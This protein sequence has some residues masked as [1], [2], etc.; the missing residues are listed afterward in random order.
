MSDFYKR[1]VKKVTIPQT[2]GERL[3]KACGAGSYREVH[4]F[5]KKKGIESDYD[6]IRK[7][8]LGQREPD[9][10][11]LVKL[12]RATGA[13][14]DWLLTGEGDSGVLEIPLSPVTGV[15][16]L[17]AQNVKFWSLFEL[18]ELQA[19]RDLAQVQRIPVEEF[20]YDLV[21]QALKF[22][23][24]I[25]Y[26]ADVNI[27]DLS[28][29][30]RS[31]KDNFVLVKING[32][33]HNGGALEA[34]KPDESGT[35][36]KAPRK[37]FDESFIRPDSKIHPSKVFG[38]KIETDEIDA[39]GFLCG[40][41]I[42][43]GDFPDEDE[44]STAKKKGHAVAV[45]SENRSS[46]YLRRIYQNPYIPKKYLFRPLTQ[47]RPIEESIRHRKSDVKFIYGVVTGINLEDDC[48]G[49]RS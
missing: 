44:S 45:I 3:Y 1:N 2:F 30:E 14:L 35:F 48:S 31:H 17:I 25:D 26:P 42:I 7:Y 5:L 8:L 19:I 36:V 21:K 13:N 46:I 10:D 37:W 49:A 33:I 20:L 43:C 12:S 4:S 16:P 18:E 32:K 22:N 9:M 15:V 38:I 34:S 23:D 40:D 6:T 41:I 11:T 47:R 29:E 24:A 28:I 39:D 27:Y